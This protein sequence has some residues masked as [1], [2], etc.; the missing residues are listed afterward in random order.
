MMNLLLPATRKRN[1]L[2]DANDTPK[3]ESWQYTF[4][5][6]NHLEDLTKWAMDVD[7]KWDKLSEITQNDLRD[8]IFRSFLEILSYRCGLDYKLI[9]FKQAGENF[10]MIKIKMG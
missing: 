3:K 9:D 8:K 1:K 7:Y 4:E 10:I 2:A 5:N 6:E